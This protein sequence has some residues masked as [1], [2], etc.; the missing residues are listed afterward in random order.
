MDMFDRNNELSML[1]IKQ[2]VKEDE[3]HHHFLVECNELC[4]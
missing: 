2:L 1:I 3:W 4:C